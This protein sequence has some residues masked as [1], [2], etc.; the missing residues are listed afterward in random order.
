[1][2][3]SQQTTLRVAFYSTK[4]Y[5]SD[6]FDDQ[7]SHLQPDLKIEF[8]YLEPRL[9]LTTVPL[10]KGHDAV[11]IFVNDNADAA[12]L[13]GLN[14]LGIKFVALRCAGFNNV[15]LKKA[16]ELGI[17]VSRVPAYSPDAVAEFA[18]GMILTV[19]RK[20]HKAYNRVREGNFLLEGLLGFN[21]KQSTVG[22]IGTGK[23]GLLTG[24]ILSRGFGARV[25]AYDPYPNPPVAEEY[26][27]T[28]VTLD[29]LLAQSD[30]ISLH[31]PLTPENRY[32][33]NGSA[34]GKMKEGVVLV[35][36]SRGALIDTKALIRGLKEGKIKAVGMDVYEKES[37]YFFQDGSE[38]IMQDDLLA[39]LISFHNVFISGHQAFLTRE[40]LASIA[41]TTIDN[42]V[43]LGS[44]K[45]CKNVVQE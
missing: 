15:D 13:E 39:R 31:C 12:V 18:V 42:V 26:G 27:I 16:K 9:S 17:V 21:I 11:C 2:S 22:L 7:I 37:E 38:G 10:A 24:K 4:H 25:I 32:L 23:I 19:I 44:G 29:E 14:A 43:A 8:T 30:I 28:Y 34:I 35:N 45:E 3:S 5:D 33:I 20:Y 1:M 6:S 36:T 40:A 41:A